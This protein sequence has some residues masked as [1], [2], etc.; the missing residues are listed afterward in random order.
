MRAGPYRARAVTD[1]DA[2]LRG[3]D[4]V[5]VGGGTLSPADDQIGQKAD[6]LPFADDVPGPVDRDN[7]RPPVRIA[8]GRQPRLELAREVVYL[9]G[10]DD[11]VSL[12]AADVEPDLAEVV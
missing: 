10:I 5:D 4:V 11:P 12:T 7:G 6:A 2:V 1:D 9:G 3:A 8:E